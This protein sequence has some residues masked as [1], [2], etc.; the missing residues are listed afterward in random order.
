MKSDDSRGA[1]RLA[2]SDV[3]D[4]AGAGED[5]DSSAPT[6]GVIGETVEDVGGGGD[7][8]DVGAEDVGA[9]TGDDDGWL[10]LVF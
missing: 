10:R 7:L 1:S 4:C 6:S 8:E 3:G 5:G 2:E 9:V